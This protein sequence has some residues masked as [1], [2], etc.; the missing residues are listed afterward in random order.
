MEK[1]VACVVVTYNRKELLKESI[2]ALKKQSYENLKILIIDNASTDGTEDEIKGY[3]DEKV[4]YFNTGENL[5]GAGGFNYGMKCALRENADYIWLMDDDAIVKENTLKELL[6]FAKNINDNFGFL[7]SHVLWTDGSNCQMNLQKISLSKKLKDFKKPQKIKHASFVSFFVKSEVVEDLGLPI[8]EFFIWGD[9]WEYSS[10][11]SKK[12]NCYY[13]PSSEII[14]KCASNIGS[15]LVCD[16]K[17]RVPR[18]FYAYRNEGYFYRKEGLKGKLYNLLKRT[19]HKFKIRKS[20]VADKKERL[21]I[22]NDGY[23]ASKTFNPR[24]EYM[25]RP[26]TQINVLE[27]FGEQILYGGQEAFVI[28]MYRNF[29]DPQIKYTFFT[30]F[31]SENVNLINLARERG[32]EIIAGNKNIFSFLSKYYVITEFKKLLK[33]R[34]FDVVHIHSVGIFTLYIMSKLAKKAGVKKVIVHSHAGGIESFKHK[35]LKGYSDKRITKYADVYLACSE[36]AGEFKYPKS[37]M[38]SN[39]CLV[40]KNGIDCKKF[41][42][43]EEKREEYRKEFNLD[44][45]FVICNIGRYSDQKNQEFLVEVIKKLSEKISDF[46]VILVGEGEKKEEIH[47]KIEDYNIK[48]YFIYLERRN[49]INNILFASD[50]FVLP[51][52]FEGFPVVSIESQ[53]TGLLTLSASTITKE[54]NITNLIKFLDIDSIDTWVDEI[55]R[56]RDKKVSNRQE[57]AGIVKEE[58]FDASASAKQLESIYKGETSSV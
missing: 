27:C 22:I 43:D 9:D 40:I 37:I 58:G 4:L 31:N 24:I 44:G 10:R 49:D 8:K 46:K 32:D 55:L 45:K 13:V 28:N 11:I 26:S 14:H 2:E 15:N 56:S 19:L 12:Y 39:K 33:K 50:L 18:Y 29:K 23:K 36:L 21:E 51:S 34:K 53:C 30:S 5:G 6:D 25:Y 41:T 48:D 38:D 20:K 16:V 3:L 7:S 35:L 42:F 47:K 57:Y 1:Q 52:K 17:E 54:S